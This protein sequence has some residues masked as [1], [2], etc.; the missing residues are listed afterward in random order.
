[1]GQGVPEAQGLE[2]RAVNIAYADTHIPYADVYADAYAGTDGD[3][4]ANAYDADAYADDE[5][6]E[7][8]EE[9]GS[10]Q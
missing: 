10:S 5:D 2:E 8:E 6:E 9:H 1:M 3:A 4:Y 7:E